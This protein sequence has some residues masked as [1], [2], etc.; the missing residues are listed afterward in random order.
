MISCRKSTTQYGSFSDSLRWQSAEEATADRC[1]KWCRHTDK[2]RERKWKVHL[3]KNANNTQNITKHFKLYGV[4]PRR[5]PKR[6]VGFYRTRRRLRFGG[7][8]AFCRVV[9][10]W[11][12]YFVLCVK[13][14]CWG[15]IMAEFS[16][17]TK[18]R[19]IQQIWVSPNP[20]S[21]L[22]AGSIPGSFLFLY[23]PTA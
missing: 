20:F 17:S 15:F 13:T 8:R 6:L 2:L 21:F 16:M 1:I 7:V 5:K 4:L 18:I 12:N 23:P 10:L 22:G 3:K 14:I 11:I 19:N 9:A